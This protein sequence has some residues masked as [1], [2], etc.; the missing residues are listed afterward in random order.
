MA[1][2][3]QVDKAWI[4]FS[5]NEHGQNMASLSAMNDCL[6]DSEKGRKPDINQA[7]TIKYLCFMEDERVR[8]MMEA[9]EN[10]STD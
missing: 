10:G 7:D 3:L 9:M 5:A 8:L 2:A 1:K 4:M 6:A